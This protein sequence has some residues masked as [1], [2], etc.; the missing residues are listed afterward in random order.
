MSELME[1]TIGD[2]LTKQAQQYPDHEAVV[3]PYLGIRYTYREFDELTDTIARGFMGMGIKKDDKV[4]IWASNY[5]EWIITQFATAK[6]GAVMVTVNTNYKQFELEYLLKQ[7]DTTTLIMMQGVKDNNYVDHINGLCPE[8]K[9][10]EPGKLDASKLPFLKNVIFLDKEDQPGMFAW[11]ALFE[12]A[13]KVTPEELAQRKSELDIHDV[14]NMQYTSG[15]TGFPKGVMLTHYNLV[16]NGMAIGD[17]MKFTHDDILC[18]NVPLF[19]CF[20]CVLGV[21]ASYTHAATM[22]L[23]DHFNPV[24]V[25]NAIQMEKCTA[26]HGV[27]TMFISMLDHPD[28]DKYDFSTLRTGIMAGSPCP[29]EFM[30]RAMSDMNMSE[31][32]ITYGQTESSPAITMTTTTDPIEV[33]VATVGKKIPG[34]EAKIIDPETGEDAPY[35]TQGEIVARGYNIMKGYYKMPEATAQAIDKDGWLHTGDL[36]T[37]DD[38]GYFKITGRLKDMIIRGGEN[39]YPR[40][41]EEFLY[42]NPKVRDVQVIGVPDKR[43]GEEVLACV[44]LKDDETATEEEMIDFV[45]DG[46]SRFKSPRYIRFVDSFP[47]TASG[48]IQKYKMREWAIEELDLKDAEKIETA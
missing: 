21:M 1:I 39:I 32:T 40:E 7:S 24:K 18:I 43:Y 10:C 23:I 22:V 28:F 9:E 36:G 3:S 15:T 11:D 38:G 34:V 33:R 25:M 42:T 45:R 31:I 14:I 5:P 30:K 41:I 16:N 29:I 47:M 44:I 20:G 4:S 12:F 2:L 27:P 26:V 35:N 46:L 48:K 19:H 17:C 13:E 37:M 6:M 8:L